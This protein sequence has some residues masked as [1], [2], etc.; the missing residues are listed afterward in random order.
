M[1]T[2][3]SIALFQRNSIDSKAQPV[4]VT[5]LQRFLRLKVV[6]PYVVMAVILANFIAG[7]V[8]WLS[9][10]VWLAI[11]LAL[12]LS[13][14]FGWMAYRYAKRISLPLEAMADHSRPAITLSAPNG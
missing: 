13:G 2:T 4:S 1:Q 7:I 9:Q 14:L 10:L 11:A 6:L 5:A 3:E 8:L 12:V